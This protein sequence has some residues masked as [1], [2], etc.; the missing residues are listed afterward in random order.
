MSSTNLQKIKTVLIRKVEKTHKYIQKAFNQTELL[1]VGIVIYRQSS[2]SPSSPKNGNLYRTILL[3]GVT[4]K[5]TNISFYL[6]RFEIF[7]AVNC[8]NNKSFPYANYRD[9]RIFFKV[10]F[11]CFKNFARAHKNAKNSC[12]I[13]CIAVKIFHER[14]GQVRP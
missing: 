10:N 12:F 7:F 3:G 11:L 14:E 9:S 1:L 13:I 5:S 8:T 4:Y 2:S 6:Y